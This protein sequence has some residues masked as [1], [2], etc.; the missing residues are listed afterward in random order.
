MSSLPHDPSLKP[1]G[2][3]PGLQP[4]SL[5]SSRY[6]DVVY[7][8]VHSRYYFIHALTCHPVVGFID[9]W[10][11]SKGSPH[12]SLY[13]YGALKLKFLIHTN[14]VPISQDAS[15]LGIAS[16]CIFLRLFFRRSVA[17][18]DTFR[19]GTGHSVMLPAFGLSSLYLIGS[20]NRL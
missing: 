4:I 13:L 3:T 12:Y 18:K 10:T 20:S 17:T 7:A 1:T 14:I 16:S 5:N 15:S 6:D 11:Q 2:A 8:C 19:T 9:T